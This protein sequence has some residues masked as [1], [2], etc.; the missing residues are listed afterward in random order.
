MFSDWW[1][2]FIVPVV[3]VIWGVFAARF[4]A[5][6][7]NESRGYR[8]ARSKKNQETWDFANELFSRLLWQ[9][10]LAQGVLAFLL[11]RALRMIPHGTQAKL[12][13]V[14]TVL[15]IVCEALLKMPV[16]RALREK[17]SDD[18]EKEEEG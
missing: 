1:C 8:T 2:A 5:K 7:I 9:T 16:E 13:I 3:M 10:G 11:M 4:P 17:F 14:L 6:A 12:A 18:T 15:Q